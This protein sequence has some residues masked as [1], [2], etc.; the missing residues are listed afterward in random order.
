MTDERR[1]RADQRS[2]AHD[3]P[4]PVGTARRR[5]RL[6]TAVRRLHPEFD[7]QG[8]EPDPRFTFANERTF[9]A[10]SRTAIALI[11]GG[12]AAAEVLRF[13]LNGAHLLVAIPAILLGGLLSFVGYIRWEHNERAMRL[14][15]PLGYT[16]LVRLLATG[17]ALIAA[18]SAI[19]VIIA[20][21]VR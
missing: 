5:A 13:G 6:R 18:I 3:R 10:W 14:S 7:E 9:L 21:L 15:R 1:A 16:P 17:I 2:R 20:A 12:L 19:L 8:D 4:A 11:G